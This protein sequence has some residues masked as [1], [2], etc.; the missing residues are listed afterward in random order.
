MRQ[1]S[2]YYSIKT[3]LEELKEIK[4]IDIWMEL[5]Y[6]LTSIYFQYVSVINNK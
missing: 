3:Q 6:F 2:P 1:F 5:W 4:K